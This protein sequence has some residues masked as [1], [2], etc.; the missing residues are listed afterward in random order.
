MVGRHA[1]PILTSTALY[2]LGDIVLDPGN[3]VDGVDVSAHALNPTAHQALVSLGASL[4]A[5]LLGIS[6]QT[7][8]LDSQ[9]ANRVFAG[10]PS[11]AS[12]VP[13]FRI[14]VLDDL[15]QFPYEFYIP[16]GAASESVAP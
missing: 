13:G 11:G 3:T 10:P 2:P 5:N 15:P 16:F 12:G 8:S 1:G 14:L 9:L 4:D 6:G 7:L